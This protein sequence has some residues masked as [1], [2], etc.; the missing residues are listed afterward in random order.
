MLCLYFFRLTFLLRR[1]AEPC[2]TSST[3]SLKSR[4]VSPAAVAGLTWNEPHA[5]PSTLKYQ[6]QK[7]KFYCLASSL[8]RNARLRNYTTKRREKQTTQE[9]YG[10]LV[11][12]R[13]FKDN[14]NFRLNAVAEWQGLQNSRNFA[15]LL[16]TVAIAWVKRDFNHRS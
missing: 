1:T 12:V 16:I 11:L 8:T 15:A 4:D 2:G 9:F 13:V 5:S 14:D 6:I 7:N 10:G 3:S